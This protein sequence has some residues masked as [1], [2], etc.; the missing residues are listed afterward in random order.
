MSRGPGPR[1]IGHAVVWAFVI[2]LT[3]PLVGTLLFALAT[4]WVVTILPEGLTL[5]AV[6]ATVRHPRFGETLA[7]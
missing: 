3:A 7:R 2:A 4:R 6:L 5:D 1:L